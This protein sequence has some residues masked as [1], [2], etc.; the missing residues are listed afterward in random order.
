MIINYILDI[1]K[2]VFKAGF[3]VQNNPLNQ[4]VRVVQGYFVVEKLVGIKA[5]WY[6]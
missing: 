2:S 5:L 1:F 3:V 6:T 4:C